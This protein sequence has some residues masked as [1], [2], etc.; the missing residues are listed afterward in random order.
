MLRGWRGALRLDEVVRLSHPTSILA[1][2]TASLLAATLA[3]DIT[4][5]LNAL[6][7]AAPRP[8]PPEPP[9][10]PPTPPTP[11]SSTK[12][13]A[14]TTDPDLAGERARADLLRRSVADGAHF[15]RTRGPRQ[16]G[17][18]WR[19]TRAAT[20]RTRH[21]AGHSRWCTRSRPRSLGPKR[22]RPAAQDRPAHA[23]A[24]L[25]PRT[26]AASPRRSRT[27]PR[28]GDRVGAPPGWCHIGRL[29]LRD[30]SDLRMHDA[31]MRCKRNHRGHGWRRWLLGGGLH[32]RFVVVSTYLAL[33]GDV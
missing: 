32:E 3:Q 1:T 17:A 22:H 2:V 5:E 12:P 18:C 33:V 24:T 21:R 10:S 27:P 13:P 4:R 15:P 20:S 8:L 19:P 23:L 7:Q 26:D 29:R 16:G 25:T 6:E 30:R 11:R 14:T 9:T 28:Q 31:S